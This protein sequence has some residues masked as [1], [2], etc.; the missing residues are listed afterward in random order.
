[1]LKIFAEIFKQLSMYRCKEAL[2]LIDQLPNNHKNSGLVLSYIGRAFFEMNKYKDSEKYY[3]ECLKIEPYRL[4]GVEYFSSCL[5]HLKDQYQ[6]CNL[7]NHVLEQ[8]LFSPETW[9]VLGNCYSLQKEHEVALKFLGRAIQLNNSYAYA[10]TLCGHEHFA[11]EAYN[12]SK[13]FYSKAIS[14]DDK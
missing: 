14:I 4:E 1:M 10:Y 5:W 7:A 11:N 2:N 12:E 8:S 6:L 13:D 3:K 9:V